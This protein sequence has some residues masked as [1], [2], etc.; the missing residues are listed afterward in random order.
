MR[1]SRRTPFLPKGSRGAGGSRLPFLHSQKLIA[2][3]AHVVD[4]R[5]LPFDCWWLGDDLPSTAGIGRASYVNDRSVGERRI[6]FRILAD[7]RPPLR[8]AGTA[9]RRNAICEKQLLRLLHSVGGVF[10]VRRAG[11]NLC[12][13]LDEKG[14][15]PRALWRV[16]RR[17]YG[18]G[19]GVTDFG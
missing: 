11:E 19:A 12:D 1:T 9:K 4:A 15:L 2:R 3:D 8:C 13:V 18:T 17:S 6:A 7:N 10:R 14:P 16:D 5:F